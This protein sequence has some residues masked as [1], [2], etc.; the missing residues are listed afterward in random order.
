MRRNKERQER[1]QFHARK[2]AKLTHLIRY[3][4]NCRGASQ[5]F[6][7]ICAAYEQSVF[8]RSIREAGVGLDSESG[9]IELATAPTRWQGQGTRK[10]F[11]E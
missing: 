1:R 9:R 3:M 8:E 6:S 7:Q 10:I 2:N 5:L 11:C 4:R